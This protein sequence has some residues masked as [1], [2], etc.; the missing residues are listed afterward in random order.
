MPL[1]M[2]LAWIFSVAMIIRGVVHEKERRLKEV[3]KVAPSNYH[4]LL[5]TFL[6]ISRGFSGDWKNYVF[7]GNRSMDQHTTWGK[8]HYFRFFSFETLR[9]G[10]FTLSTQL[11]K[12]NCLVALLRRYSNT[13]YKTIPFIYLYH[14]Q[15]KLLLLIWAYLFSKLRVLINR[16]LCFDWSQ[17]SFLF[18]G[19]GSW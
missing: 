14:S 12:P 4:W 9:G 15:D 13:V 17:F 16:P 11:I 6:V 2:T 1:F 8:W 3:M 7:G 18:L 5:I 10:Q 19:D